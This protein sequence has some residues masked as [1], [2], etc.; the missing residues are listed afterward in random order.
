LGEVLAASAE[1]A[2]AGRAPA[3]REVEAYL[4]TLKVDD[5][6][7]ATACADGHEPAW[8]H[9]VREIRPVL[10]RAADA[11]DP[12]GGA[13]DLADAL[14]GELFGV[15]GSSGQRQSLFRYFH[16]R[17][18]LATWVRSVLSQRFV[19]RLRTRRRDEE[20]PGEDSPSALSTPAAEPRPEEARW[21]A[22]VHTA[23][24]GALAALDPRDRLRLACY[25]G[26]NMKLAAIGKMFGEHEATASRHL[27]R[28]REK[29]RN[30]VEQ[31]LRTVHH[32]SPQ[33]IA[34]C[35]DAAAQHAGALD[36]GAILATSSDEE[37]KDAGLERS[38]EGGGRR[39]ERA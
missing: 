33:A 1:R 36:L 16:G 7:L 35:F 12:S 3:E 28:T 15:R 8:E 22:L 34:E 29:I 21:I 25:Y 6:V 10:Y 30:V 31:E 32:M 38:R 4:R 13:R 2:F 23:L 14:Y 19:D 37:R 24:V 18:S 27:A 20:L 17:S 9:F 5:L 39:V 26:Q 11:L